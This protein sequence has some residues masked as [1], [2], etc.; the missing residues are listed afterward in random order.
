MHG[1]KLIRERGKRE[2]LREKRYKK[3]CCSQT[4]E[5]EEK[6][7]AEGENKAELAKTGTR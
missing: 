4:A 2:E 3:K 7:R 5:A 6:P 1:G